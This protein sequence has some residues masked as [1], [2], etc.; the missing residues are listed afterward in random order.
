MF[1]GSYDLQRGVGGRSVHDDAAAVADGDGTVADGEGGRE[2]AAVGRTEPEPQQVA[3][4]RWVGPVLELGAVVQD[5]VVVH[6]LDIARL[7]R[8]LEMDA[9]VL[10]DGVEDVERL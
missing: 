5:L 9:R 2:R 8:H 4:A 3:L 6:Q 1:M 7:E 10:E